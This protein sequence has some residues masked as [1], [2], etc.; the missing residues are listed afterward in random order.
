MASDSRLISPLLVLAAVLG[1]S[2]GRTAL[3]ADNGPLLIEY[4][5]S[6]GTA[7]EHQGWIHE[8]RSLRSDCPGSRSY[9]PCWFQGSQDL[10]YDGFSDNSCLPG[11]GCHKI[12]EHYNS[13][14][15]TASL[16]TPDISY[17]E[18]IGFDSPH[19]PL[20]I[21][22]STIPHSP[23]WGAASF[24]NAPTYPVLRVVTGDGNNSP[25]SLPMS[26]PNSRNMGKTKIRRGFNPGTTGALTLILHAAAGPRPGGR[27]FV[28][29]RAFQ[30]RFGFGVEGTPGTQHYG[31]LTCVDPGV[32][33]SETSYQVIGPMFGQ[34]VLVAQPGAPGPH[35]GEFF[36]LR[37]IVRSDGTFDAYLNEN[38]DQHFTG[39]AAPSAASPPHELQLTPVPGDDTMWFDFVQLF[40]GEIP[41]SCPAPAVDANRDG[42]VDD[43][44]FAI[45]LDC[46]NGPAIPLKDAFE[47][48]CMDRNADGALD[49]VDFG[50]L[51]RCWAPTGAQLN[52]AC[53]D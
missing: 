8:G 9:A 3:R 52:P 51:Q 21:P 39:V 11:V 18:W 41:L 16:G 33:L 48:R 50:V 37:V 49:A 27:H 47:C 12:S 45:F 13:P 20:T 34:T 19:R 6:L 26:V 29:L 36:R 53:A 31:R 44:D 35:A 25:D 5:S 28:E 43:A 1:W 22:D 2:T 14:D 7:P 32:Q 17:T 24:L 38:A 23:P 40:E 42:L 10:N 4:R 46:A 30:R 15:P